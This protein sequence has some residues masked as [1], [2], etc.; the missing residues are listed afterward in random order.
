[1]GSSAR[2]F[3][4][5]HIND[6]AQERIPLILLDL[7][8]AFEDFNFSRDWDP[9]LKCGPTNSDLYRFVQRCRKGSQNAL[10]EFADTMYWTLR[11]PAFD[12]FQRAHGVRAIN[13]G[14]WFY[15]KLFQF[16]QALLF[17]K[18]HVTGPWEMRW[19]ESVEMLGKDAIVIGREGPVVHRDELQDAV[20]PEN[21]NGRL[22]C[23]LVET[24]SKNSNDR[25]TVAQE[26]LKSQQ[27]P[28]QNSDKPSGWTKN[29]ERDQI[30]MNCLDRAMKLEEICQQLDNRTIPTLPAL[31]AK[32]IHRWIDGWADARTRKAIQQLFSKLPK[33]AM[34]VKPLPV[35]K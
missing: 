31:R 7:D 2:L 29:Q 6:M 21:N 9:T 27:A 10:G 35:S 16:F 18:A 1:M 22:W 32:D 5:S 19:V 15:Y 3:S 12:A 20:G 34:P 14:E 4:G 26:W 30:I 17:T 28:E 33:R 11:E 23:D 13:Y 8:P 25:L 24:V